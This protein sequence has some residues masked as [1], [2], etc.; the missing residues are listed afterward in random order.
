[1]QAN[2]EFSYVTDY[3]TRTQ[4]LIKKNI[5]SINETQRLTEDKVSEER[6]SAQK[7][8]RKARISEANKG[9]D[10]YKVFPLTL[11]T[12]GEVVLKTDTETKSDDKEKEKAKLS[13]KLDDEE[14]DDDSEETYPHGIEPVKAETLEIVRDLISLSGPAKGTAKSN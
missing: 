2:P 10:P 4:T 11:D 3:V 7:A 1:M 13:A 8:E 5:L 6:L 12:V 14:E 9:G